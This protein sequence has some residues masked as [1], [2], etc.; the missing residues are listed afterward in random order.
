MRQKA[1]KTNKIYFIVEYKLCI[2]VQVGEGVAAAACLLD[3]GIFNSIDYWGRRNGGGTVW[4]V[5]DAGR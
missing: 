4:G 3:A 1:H 2:P 5:Q